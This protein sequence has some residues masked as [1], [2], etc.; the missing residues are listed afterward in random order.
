MNKFGIENLKPIAEQL[1]IFGLA[2]G[3]LKKSKNWIDR[4]FILFK[5]IKLGVIINAIKNREEIGEEIKDISKDEIYELVIYLEK[6]FD[7]I[8]DDLESV[9]LQ[10]FKFLEHLFLFI[11]NLKKK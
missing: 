5:A 9:I 2:I 10:G 11:N 8:P 7:L 1:I 3:K 4:I 6:K